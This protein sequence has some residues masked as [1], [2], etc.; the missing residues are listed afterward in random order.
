MSRFAPNQCNVAILLLVL[1]RLAVAAD[2]PPSYSDH[3]DLLHYLD[4]DGK[5]H[6][7]RTPAEWERRRDHVLQNMQFVTGSLP[8]RS[9]AV[10]L[11]VKVESEERV[12]ELLRRGLTFRSEPDDRVPAYLFIPPLKENQKVP[13]ILCL[14][15]TTRIGKGEPAGLGPKINLHYA[16]E[17]ANRGYVTLAPDYPSFGDHSYDFAAHPQWKSGTMKAIWDNTRAIDLLRS[18]PHVDPI[19]I[20][21]IGHSLGG[22][23]AVFT[24]V[25]DDRIQVVV[26]SCGFTRFHKYYDG[27]LKGWTSDRYMPLIA[28][29]YNNDPDKVPFDFPELL[30]AIAP[31]SIFVS[32]PVRDDNFEVS[33]VKES[34]AAAE[35]IYRLYNASE[36]LT[37]IYPD[38]AHD[39][40][41][42]AREQAY[43]FLDRHL[44]RDPRANNAQ[45]R[46]D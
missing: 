45:S 5:K 7:V 36:R 35:P 43:R 28:Q 32:A 40:P 44:L 18:L 8:D 21:A 1:C 2:Q 3:L 27:N 33:G 9:K 17:L 6:P 23:N 25:F 42:D 15:Q 34:V 46:I 20:A 22:H 30:A 24:A 16:L 31:R 41:R 11:D 29:V 19:R 39:F 37:A 12:G 10:T 38:A 4:R 13:A 14:H 26:T